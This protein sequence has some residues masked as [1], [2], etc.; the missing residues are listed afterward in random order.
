MDETALLYMKVALS[1]ARGLKLP[2]AQAEADGLAGRALTS[3]LIETHEELVQALHVEVALSRARGLKHH[4][5]RAGRR[6]QRAGR[7]LTSAWIETQHEMD[8]SSL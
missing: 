1:R 2:L 4:H 6:H 5:E 3:D 7:A 8:G